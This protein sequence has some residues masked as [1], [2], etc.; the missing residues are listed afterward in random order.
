MP[1]VMI[2]WPDILGPTSEIVLEEYLFAMLVSLAASVATYA[3]YVLF[4]RDWQR[5]AGIHRVFLLAGPAITLLFIAIQWSLPLSLGLLGALSFVRFRTPIK[6]PAEIGYLLVIIASSIGAATYNYELVGILFAIV[7]AVLIAQRIFGSTGLR[8]LASGS[9]DLII[10]M[11]AED[12]TEHESSL[13]EFLRANLRGFKVASTTQNAGA[14]SLHIN[15][16]RSRLDDRWG[17]FRQELETVVSP[18]S[19]ELYVG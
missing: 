14:A 18:A 8:G 1:I 12:Y 3:L 4:Y 15:F 11:P 2:E 6:D 13:L 10:T 19:V 7:A 16:R 17:E 5:G 9:R